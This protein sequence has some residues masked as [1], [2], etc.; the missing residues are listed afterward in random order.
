MSKNGNLVSTDEEKLEVLSNNFASVFTGNL[1][2]P[3]SPV[4]GL[5]DGDQRRKAPPTVKEDQI[6]DYSP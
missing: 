1:F 2:P 4:D 3:H 5:Q 6:R